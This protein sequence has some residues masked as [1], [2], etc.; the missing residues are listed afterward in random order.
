LKKGLLNVR[1][2]IAMMQHETNTFSPVPTPL[3]RFSRGNNRPIPFEGEE[4]LLNFKGTGTTLGAFINLAEAEGAELVMPIAANASPSGPVEDLAYCYITERVYDAVAHRCDAILLHLHGAMVTES[5]EDGEGHFLK[6]VRE[7]APN[8]PIGVALD[9][10]TNLYPAMIKNTNVIAGYQTYP[11]IDMYETGIR[12]GAA[13]IALAK[14]IASPTM[15]WGNRPMLPHVMR[16]GSDDHP[17]KKIQELARQM[18]K[19]GALAASFFVGFPHADIKLAGSSAVVVTDNDQNAADT[20]C[21]KLLDLAWE[22]RREFVYTP[23]PLKKSLD[24]AKSESKGPVVLLDHYDNAASGGSMDTMDVV[25]GILE[26]GLE[27]V[28]VFAICDPDAVKRMVKIGVGNQITTSLGGNTNMPSIKQKGV[29]L[30]VKGKVKLIS[31]GCFQNIGAMSRG[32]MMDMGTTIVLDMGTVEV[33]VVSTQV[34][35]YDLNCF[36]SLGIDP[37]LKRYVMLKSRV[38][39]RAGLGALAKSVIE[40]A[41]V[42]VCTSDYKTLDFK[43]IRRPIFPLDEDLQP[44]SSNLVVNV[45]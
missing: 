22:N 8:T 43:K 26:A 18:E 7:L 15:A 20:M 40:C 27:D 3:E 35:P 9:M 39:W 5:L 41:G 25:K 29:P 28:V 36:L 24:Q 30:T 10:H 4:V 1:I 38:H 31:N 37:R 45:T 23:E 19:D 11:H 12:V 34:E 6:K 32:T 17:N 33:V 14:G 44:Y 21:K 16:Q 2:V 13:T 42:G